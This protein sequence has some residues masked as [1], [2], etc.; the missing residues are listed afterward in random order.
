MEAVVGV[1]GRDGDRP[2]AL[3]VVLV[4]LSSCE[5]VGVEQR[6]PAGLRRLAPVLEGEEDAGRVVDEWVLWRR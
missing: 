3:V 6:R 1:G 4:V 5:I 2:V